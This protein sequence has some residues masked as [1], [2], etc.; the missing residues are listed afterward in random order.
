MS[1]ETIREVLLWCT[2]IN[3][4][5]LLVWFLFILSARDWIHRLHGRWFR[6]SAER[7][8]AIHYAGMA[9]YKIGILAFNL[10]P[11]V[12]LLIVGDGS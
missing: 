10:V 7:F 3:Y 1:I 2:V 5:V 8:D 6:L 11:Y 12:S 9:V 4:G